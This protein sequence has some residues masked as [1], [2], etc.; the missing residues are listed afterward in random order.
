MREPDAE[1]FGGAGPGLRN[2]AITELRCTGW[3]DI[4][5]GLRRSAA[6]V[7]DLLVDR[8]FI[9]ERDEKERNK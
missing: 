7:E 2:P 5:A 9:P 6:R 8:A 4:A 1:R 3:S